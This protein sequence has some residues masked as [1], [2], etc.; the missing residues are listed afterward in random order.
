[1]TVGRCQFLLEWPEWEPSIHESEGQISRQGR[2]MTYPF[3]FD[4]NVS[5]GTARFSST[6]DLPYYDTSLSRCDCYD[7]QKR[8]IPCKHMYRLAVELGVIK[9]VRRPGGGANKALLAEIK[10]CDD[11][12]SHP[13]QLKR[14]E[15]AK[16]AKMSPLSIDYINKTARFSGSGKNPYE[17]TVDSCTCK[18]F[19]VRQLPCKHIYRLRIELEI[20]AQK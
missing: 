7:F 11:I 8:Q 9:I 13:E 3:T 16:S 17:T 6:S 20:Y 10:T 2:A 15:S 19:Y 12:D 18:D 14:L 5:A 4:V 1:M